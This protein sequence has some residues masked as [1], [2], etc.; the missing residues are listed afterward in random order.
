MTSMITE[1][2]A[3]VRVRRYGNI[4]ECDVVAAFRGQEMSIRWRDYSQAVKWARVESKTYKIA[5]GF[6]VEC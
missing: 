1:H 2:P 6:I 5:S 3:E 4:P